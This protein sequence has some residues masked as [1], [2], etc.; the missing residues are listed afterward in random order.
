MSTKIREKFIERMN[1]YGL[2]KSTQKSYITGVIGLADFYNQSPDTL[3]DD[4]VRGYFR[5]LLTH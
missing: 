2:T 3:T 1:L 5:H 4:Q